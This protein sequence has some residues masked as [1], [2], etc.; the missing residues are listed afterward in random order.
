MDQLWCAL[1]K[2]MDVV[3]FTLDAEGKF[4]SLNPMAERVFG[5]HE[6]ELVGKPFTTVLD[7]F[8]HEKAAMML[9]RTLKEG[10]VSEWELDHLQ[11]GKAPIL[12]GYSTTVLRDDPGNIVGL[13]AIGVDLTSK[14]ELTEKLALTNQTLEGALLKLEKTLAELKSAQSQLVQAEKMR[15]LG[16]L[17]AGIAHEI[18]NPA[19]FVSN[20]L[21]H[22]KRI[23]PTLRE[24]FDA[25]TPLKT[26]A[27][28][29]QLDVI[30]HAEVAAELDYLWDDLN[31][32]TLESQDGIERIRR[33]V[34]SLRTF[35]H[36]DE[37]VLKQVDLSE[38]LLSTLQ[39]VR[40]MCKHGIQLV[41]NIQ[42]LPLIYAHPGELNQ[43]F[44]NLLTNAVQAIDGN[45]QIE[46]ATTQTDDKIVVSIRDTGSGMDAET[47]THLGEP[48]FT[49]KSVGAGTG[50]GLSI[51]YGII[52]RHHGKL[53]FESKVGSGTTAYVELPIS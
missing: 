45:G 2:Q 50:L 33:I 44:L 35:S 12:L 4:T 38:G 30:Q 7:P 47:L 11:S 19:A 23:L 28:P 40:P 41:E 6:E 31:D 8:S 49:T 42:Q 36:L 27:S 15:T 51:S 14:L 13:G 37:A 48:F 16:Q 18:N 20:N 21:A 52:E 17:V 53:R 34:L 1:F 24:L 25:Y 43:V 39:L 26:S 9:E 3:L 32:I 29:E 22:L 10:G 46:I 5:Y